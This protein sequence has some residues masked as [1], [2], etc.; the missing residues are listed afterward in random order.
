MEEYTY[1]VIEELDVKTGKYISHA[2]RVANCNNLLSYFKPYYGFK[3]ISI[4]AC[5]TLKKSKEIA[6]YWNEG[7]LKNGKYALSDRRVYPA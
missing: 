4:N 2:E 1:F 7:A 6:D 5:D 3:I